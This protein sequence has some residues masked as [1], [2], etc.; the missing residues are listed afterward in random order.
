MF[1]RV[2]VWRERP[3][4]IVLDG[5]W[6]TGVFDRVVVCRDEAGH[7]RRAS[8]YDFKTD[9]GV[10]RGLPQAA[11]KHA[12]QITLYQRVVAKLTGLPVDAVHA[13]VVFTEAAKKVAVTAGA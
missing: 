10:S 8:V 6:V 7:V 2:E 9:R 12:G 1:A 11:N 3:F 13:E 5:S 4:E